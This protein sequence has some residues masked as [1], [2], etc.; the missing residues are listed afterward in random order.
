MNGY[1]YSQF[2]ESRENFFVTEDFLLNAGKGEFC[3]VE[4]QAIPEEKLEKLIIYRW[5]KKYPADCFL[6]I[7]LNEWKLKSTI[8]F[9]GYSHEKIMKEEYEK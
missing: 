8:E 2:D 6:N 9:E 4:N 1:S 3:F 7:N 5:D